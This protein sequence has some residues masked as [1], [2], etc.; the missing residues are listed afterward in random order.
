V[1]ASGTLRCTVARGKLAVKPGLMF[2]GGGHLS[3]VHP[4]PGW[5]IGPWPGAAARSCPAQVGAGAAAPVGVAATV[6]PGRDPRRTMV[7]AA[8]ASLMVRA[9]ADPATAMTE[10]TRKA[11]W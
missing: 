6:F 10:A 7:A 1:N 11:A 5:L 2:G 9:T 3:H 8:S 4:Y